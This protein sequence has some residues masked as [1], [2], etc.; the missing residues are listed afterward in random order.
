ME[1]AA[2]MQAPKQV[3]AEAVLFSGLEPVVVQ[4][5]EVTGLAVEP[6]VHGA[7]IPLEQPVMLEVERLVMAMLA[8]VE[9]S[10]VVMAGQVEPVEPQA[11]AESVEQVAFLAVGAVAAE[12]PLTLVLVEQAGKAR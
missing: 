6:V 11:Q 10:A 4:P 2:P 9:I 3:R 5:L 1:V 8:P 12:V 7:V